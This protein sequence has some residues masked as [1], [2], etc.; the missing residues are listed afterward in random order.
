MSSCLPRAGSIAV[1]RLAYLLLTV[2]SS[3]KPQFFGSSCK[4]E[5]VRQLNPSCHVTWL[6]FYV[7]LQPAVALLTVRI[8]NTVRIMSA[9]PARLRR[10]TWG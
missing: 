9:A 10:K 8:M 2:L 7:R 6:L 5:F 3:A 4:A 1:F